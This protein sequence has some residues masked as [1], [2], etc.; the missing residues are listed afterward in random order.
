MNVWNRP[1]LVV[2]DTLSSLAGVRRGDAE[3][4]ARLQ[5]FLLHL[6]Q[7]RRAVLLVHHANK[8]GA[9]RGSTRRADPLDLVIALQRPDARTRCQTA[10]GA[11]F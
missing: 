3:R 6:R 9:M 11:R 10:G 8:Q 4:W 2:V 5:R 7:H 1:E